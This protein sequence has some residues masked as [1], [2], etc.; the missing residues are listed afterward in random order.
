[1]VDLEEIGHANGAVLRST[2][3]RGYGA[4]ST[5]EFSS[6]INPD[7]NWEN[8]QINFSPE[9]PY[10]EFDPEPLIRAIVRVTGIP[11]SE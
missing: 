9:R 7:F 8:G 11:A 3:S 1:M 2:E 10:G 6:S 4:E 5:L